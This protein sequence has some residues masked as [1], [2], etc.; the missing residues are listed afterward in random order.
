MNYTYDPMG[1]LVK[2]DVFRISYNIRT[3][4]L[5]QIA[6]YQAVF[7]KKLTNL[8]PDLFQSSFN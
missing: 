4:D 5:A 6:D 2:D 1:N 8:K 7:S 3:L